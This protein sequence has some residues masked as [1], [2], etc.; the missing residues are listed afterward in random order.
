MNKRELRKSRLSNL[1]ALNSSKRS[2]LSHRIA[3]RFF[4]HF[5]LDEIRYL[6]L[7]LSIE[8]KNEVDTRPLIARIR[9]EH[10]RISIAVPRV[11]GDRLDT[12]LYD[13]DSTLRLSNWNV[14]EPIDDRF[15][16]PRSIDLVI[17]PLLAFDL[18]G[19]RVGYGKG[20]Y[21]RFLTACRD[22]C[23]KVGISF[24]PPVENIDDVTENDVRLDF[25][26]TPF[27][28]FEF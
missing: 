11:N 7:F 10:P 17:V 8:A 14:P 3:G 1:K 18:R 24:F 27:E 21:D 6:H 9:R 15:V 26:L 2:N 22:D 20:F 16:D 5:Q 23:V 19:H 25:C 12:L 4:G 28:L 13:S